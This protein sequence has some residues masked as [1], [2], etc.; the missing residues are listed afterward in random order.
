M[1]A[2]C[3]GYLLYLKPLLPSYTMLNST[4]SKGGP[5][6]GASVI[7]E[8]VENPY[9]TIENIELGPVPGEGPD[10]PP[11]PYLP[12]WRQRFRDSLNRNVPKLALPL[13]VVIGGTITGGTTFLLSEHV[14]K[15]VRNAR[16]S[17]DAGKWMNKARGVYDAC[18]LGCH[19]CADPAYSYKACRRTASFR[20]PDTDSVCDGTVIWNWADRYPEACLRTG[21]EHLRLEALE[22]LKRSY[23]NQWALIILTILGGILGGIGVYI[24]WRRITAGMRARAEATETI[25]PG[26]RRRQASKQRRQG[27]KR[28]ALTL[29]PLFAK[30][31][32]AYACIER[33]VA[34]ISFINGNKTI[35]VNVHAWLS[36]CDDHEICSTSMIG[37]QT[38][39]TCTTFVEVR[40]SPIHYVEN[41]IPQITAC[42]FYPGL[43][44]D[45]PVPSVRLANPGFEKD[46]RVR[47]DVNGYNV[48]NAEK[49][50]SEISCLHAIG[51]R[52][53]A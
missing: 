20:T 15:L 28:T 35:S 29:L 2:T 30:T 16:V 26:W 34:D 37:V 36:D 45:A 50:D 5:M 40:A 6:P 21:G 51:D 17:D 31:A 8:A 33:P 18:Y 52:K 41:I 53:S 32:S 44:D 47:L 25:W 42:G 27:W 19:D 49:T 22:A 13:A 14:S 48:T 4:S 9:S 12:G 24:L 3:H 23:L 1:F 39:T 38:I 10:A 11:P 7:S 43:P 46:W